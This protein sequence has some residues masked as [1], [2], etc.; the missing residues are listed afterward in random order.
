VGEL[1]AGKRINYPHTAGINQT[2]KKAPRARN[3]VPQTED[4]FQVKDGD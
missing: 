1:L 4:L 2:F 3:T